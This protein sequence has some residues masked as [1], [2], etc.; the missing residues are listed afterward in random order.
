MLDI[1]VGRHQRTRGSLFRTCIFNRHEGPWDLTPFLNTCRLNVLVECMCRSQRLL[2]LWRW[3]NQFLIFISRCWS[4]LLRKDLNLW[5]RNQ[6][7]ACEIAGV[8]LALARY[9]SMKY[10]F[11]A[12]GNHTRSLSNTSPFCCFYFP[13]NIWWTMEKTPWFTVSQNNTIRMGKIK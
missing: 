13:L 3:V 2:N 6:K 11:T 1:G 4:S 7:D 12:L 9:K 10:W 5:K 8:S